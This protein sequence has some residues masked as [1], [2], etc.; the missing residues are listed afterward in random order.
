MDP[1]ELELLERLGVAA[2]TAK[3]MVQKIIPE[4]EVSFVVPTTY[5]K[6]YYCAAALAS[7]AKSI[8]ATEKGFKI[9]YS[10]QQLDEIGITYHLLCPSFDESPED[11]EELYEA[12]DYLLSM[13]PIFYLAD[14]ARGIRGSYYDAGGQTC[15][16]TDYLFSL[17]KFSAKRFKGRIDEIY[18]EL[19]EKKDVLPRWSSEFSL[20]MLIKDR[21]GDV[22]YQYRPRWLEPQSI[23]IFLSESNIGIEYQGIQHYEPIERFG[24]EEG[25]RATQARDNKKRAL[26]KQN[27][28]NL[29]EWPYT[30]EISAENVEAFLVEQGVEIKH[31]LITPENVEEQMQKELIPVILKKKEKEKDHKEKA[32][33]ERI[34]QSVIRQY[35]TSGVFVA[36]YKTMQEAAV[37]VGISKSS[38]NKAVTGERAVS[39]GYQWRRV[40]YGA[41]PDAIGEIIPR[42][43]EPKAYGLSEAKEVRQYTLDGV[44]VAEYASIGLATKSAGISRKCITDA[45]N[46]KQ[47]TAGG[48]IWK[49]ADTAGND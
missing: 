45:I 33:Q 6:K 29:I 22:I 2:K 24:G 40:P 1:D 3:N 17:A 44:F 23:D 10:T 38:V 27:L 43:E 46:G 35:D 39:G 18:N 31:L 15:L 21:V 7:S 5:N 9:T 30:K 13:D 11:D 4:G 26:C 49:F 48:Y 8:E 20:Y 42:K 12:F 41:P 25:F 19:L 36:D 37:A 32:P 34:P 28:L 16:V 14:Q 47:K